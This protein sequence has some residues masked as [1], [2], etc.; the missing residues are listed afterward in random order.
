MSTNPAIKTDAPASAG[1]VAPHPLLP[2]RDKVGK[3]YCFNC[4]VEEHQTR[5]YNLAAHMLG[6]WSQ[7]ED[8]TQEAFISAYRS[9]NKYRGEN[10]AAWL[11]RIVANYCRDILRVRKARPAQ[12]LDLQPI[13][14][15]DHEATNH[16][17]PE[18]SALSRELQQAIH[19]GLATLHEDQRLVIILIDIEGFSYEAAA[20]ALDCNIGTIKSRLSRGR[21][22]LRNY[23]LNQG[24]L[25]PLSFRQDK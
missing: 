12:P 2:I 4:V 24:E 19:K 6:D 13:D 18:N 23:L 10:L 20:Q 16:S 3:E 25:L 8:A 9:F 1:H 21:A 14:P 17:S 15:V 7:A 5:A 22:T 11:M